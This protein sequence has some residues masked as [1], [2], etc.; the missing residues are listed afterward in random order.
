MRYV[1]TY[2]DVHHHPNEDVVFRRLSDRAPHFRLKIGEMLAQHESII[3]KGQAFLR[4]IESV[5]EDSMVERSQF[6]AAGR[7]YLEALDEH[8]SIEERELFPAARQFL[9]GE[10]WDGVAR[11]INRKADPLFDNSM[12][13][14]YGRLRQ[15]IDAHT[16]PRAD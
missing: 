5:E 10:D 8:M 15:R 11:S 14:V 9:N 2:P 4:L 13:R 3:A 1:A 16:G 12:D 6:V 7:A